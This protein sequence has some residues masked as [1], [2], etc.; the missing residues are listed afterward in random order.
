MADSVETLRVDLR[1]RVEK[2]G[3]SEKEDVAR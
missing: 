2:L 1:T 3:A